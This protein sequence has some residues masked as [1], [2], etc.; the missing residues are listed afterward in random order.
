MGAIMHLI[1]NRNYSVTLAVVDINGELVAH[2]DF[3]YL[4]PPRRRGNRDGQP[5]IMRPGE[6][7]EI[8]KHDDDRRG[9]QDILKE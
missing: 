3:L 7:D 9:F 5:P 1:D 2:K 4:M 6:E 8:R